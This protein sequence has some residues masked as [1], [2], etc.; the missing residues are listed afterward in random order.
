MAKQTQFNKSARST[1]FQPIQVS[2]KEIANM[3][4]ESARV[5]EGM[6]RARQSE[7]DERER[8]QRARLENQ[9]LEASDRE[10]NLKILTQNAETE[11]QQLRLDSQQK[12][13]QLELNQKASAE[14]FKSVADF[15]KT[16]LSQLQKMDEARFEED[17]LRA[18]QKGL[19]GDNPL[20]PQQIKG[21]AELQAVEEQRRGLIDEGAATG[22][23]DPLTASQL[24]SMSSGTRLGLEQAA[25][26]YMLTE[27][28][29][30]K[31]Q[32]AIAEQPGM[33]SGSTSEFLTTFLRDFLKDEQNSINGKLLVDLK[34]ELLRVGVESIN[35]LHQSIQTKANA[36]EARDLADQRYDDAKTIL[37]QNPAQF[38]DNIVQSFRT[39]ESDF[40]RKVAHQTYESLA[41]MRKPNGEFMFTM[42]QLASTVLTKSGKAYSDEWPSRFAAM[43]EARLTADNQQ[44]KAIAT[45]DNLAFREAEQKSLAFLTENNTKAAA[46]QAVQF[47]I[48][49]YGRVPQSILKFQTS[50]TFEAQAKA[51]QIEDLEAIPSGFLTQEAVDAMS[52][53]DPT[54]GREMATRFAAQER[55]YN[56]GTF[57]KQSD[58]FKGVANGITGFGSN[59]AD[60]PS[61]VFLQQQIRAEYRRRVDEAVA[62]G[63]DFNTAANTIAMQLQNEVK[64]GARIPGNKWER[65][66][67]KAGGAADFPQLNEGNVSKVEQA[68]QNYAALRKKITSS[69]DG[70]ERVLNTPES[71][72][73]RDEAVA[74]LQN[75]GKPGFVIPQ[76]VLAVSTLGNGTDPF[77]II[78]RQLDAL[79]LIQLEPP[80][81]TQDVNTEL[82]PDLRK[83]LYSAIAGPRQKMRALQTGATRT[84]GDGSAFRSAGAMRVGSPMRRVAGS[85]QENAF[86]QAIRTVEGTSGPQGYNTV[87]GGAVVPQLTQ[88]TLRELYDAIKLGGSDAIPARLGGGKI[89]FKK[90]K[91]NSSASGALQLMP[92][93]LRGLVERSGFSWDDTFSPETQDRMMLT[94]AREGGVDIENMSPAQMEKAGN[95]WAG[96]SPRYGQTTRTAADSYAIYQRLLQQ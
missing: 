8:Q 50:Y 15:S 30:K 54:K 84:T 60:L 70:M 56:S 68:R 39:W 52:A 36:R 72:I 34:P 23:I 59:K 21:E 17:R 41:T 96:A 94:L 82:A 90:D 65:K 2:G 89:P 35:K 88:M 95:I 22:N 19:L 58:S 11:R 76:D 49:T 87:Y 31:L 43:K 38:G 47:F 16:A 83:Q 78:N 42:E 1:G 33:D 32:K 61:S 93:T 6:R 55:R 3:R 28:Y 66:P 9:R 48:E 63:A 91:Y 26:V 85:R 37:T 46:D 77:T 57:K 80:Q 40:G 71:I 75:Y 73:T 14:V 18:Y 4:S 29:N 79:G 27:V 45:A 44:R 62:G 53:L 92:E 13:K 81:M 51:K 86:I 64:E 67:S 5:A 25:G 10:R 74:I 24:K 69:K 12:L 20:L 7:V